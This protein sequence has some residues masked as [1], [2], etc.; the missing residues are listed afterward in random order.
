MAFKI[1]HTY[2]SGE[3]ISHLTADFNFGKDTAKVDHNSVYCRMNI[4]MS[5]SAPAWLIEY[6]EKHEGAKPRDRGIGEVCDKF[7]G[8]GP[9]IEIELKRHWFGLGFTIEAA[10]RQYMGPEQMLDLKAIDKYVRTGEEPKDEEALERE[11]TKNDPTY[12]DQGLL[13]LKASETQ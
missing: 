2:D 11:R 9:N 5:N 3:N 10:S 12:Y 13:E 6:L 4:D 8:M 1:K 7:V